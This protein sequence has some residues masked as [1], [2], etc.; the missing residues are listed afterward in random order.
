MSQEPIT[1]QQPRFP[2][3]T[4]DDRA[5][6]YARLLGVATTQLPSATLT[7]VAYRVTA[8]D[9]RLGQPFATL[10][11]AFASGSHLD[12]DVLVERPGD[13]TLFSVLVAPVVLDDTKPAGAQI[14]LPVAPAYQ[15]LLLPAGTVIYV[16]R[17]LT[18]TG[19]G[20]GNAID[21][22]LTPAV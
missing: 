6:L 19:T 16:Q 9:T 15:D 13:V 17:T 2:G 20:I 11:K 7:P 4:L 18:G 8:Q 1:N 21:V 5:A 22:P 3:S 12:V 14:D 10:N